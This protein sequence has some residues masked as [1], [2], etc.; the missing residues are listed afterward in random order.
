MINDNDK[1]EST[2]QEEME[3]QIPLQCDKNNK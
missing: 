2:L 3:K 1:S